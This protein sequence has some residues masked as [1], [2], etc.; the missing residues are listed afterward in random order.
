MNWRPNHK[1]LRH[2]KSACAV[3]SQEKAYKGRKE[4]AAGNED[5]AAVTWREISVEDHAAVTLGRGHANLLPP[6]S[7]SDFGLYFEELDF[8]CV[9]A[10]RPTSA[11][12]RVYHLTEAPQMREKFYLN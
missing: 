1:E 5:N 6:Q 10:G 7:S 2:N 8:F 4:G 9:A 11:T 3:K 12:R